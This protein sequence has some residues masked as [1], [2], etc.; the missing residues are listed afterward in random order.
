MAME[1]DSNKNV[2]MPSTIGV[3]ST[4]PAIGSNF[5]APVMEAINTAR[6]LAMWQKVPSNK[7]CQSTF[8]IISTYS[9]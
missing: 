5:P 4:P 6:K 7:K 8:P 3:P 1:S 9:R 2:I